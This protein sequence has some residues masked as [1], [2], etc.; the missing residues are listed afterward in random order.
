V[1]GIII[2]EGGNG[3]GTV[4]VIPTNLSICL[5]IARVVADVPALVT[6]SAG[7][8]AVE[9]CADSGARV[10]NLSLGTPNGSVAELALIRQLV[11]KENIAVV[12]AAGNT[13]DS[14]Y[15][16]PAA[17]SE[18]ISVAAV[19]KDLKRASFSTYNRQVD[20]AAPG[21]EVLTT[22]PKQFVIQDSKGNKLEAYRFSDSASFAGRISAS[23]AD[24]GTMGTTCAAGNNSICMI[25]RGTTTFTIKAVNAAL[26]GCRA[27]IHYNN[28]SFPLDDI[29]ISSSFAPIPIPVLGVSRRTGL[30]LLGSKAATLY[31]DTSTK[32]Y[33]RKQDGTSMAAPHVTGAIAKIWAARPKCTNKQVREAIQKTARDLGAPGRDDNTGHGLVQI[34]AAYNVSG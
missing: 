15:S 31:R 28:I 29:L 17:Y 18:A 7:M 26:S 4:G 6:S 23:I 5:L 12:A 25:E 30:R 22:I 13:G 10:I 14:N 21:V 34:W 9:W 2:A 1:A 11:D 3:K 32:G 20:I 19:D 8:A 24:C 33:Y 16:F 27:A